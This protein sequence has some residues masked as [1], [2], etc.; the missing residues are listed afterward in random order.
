MPAALQTR[1]ERNHGGVGGLEP[2]M[3]AKSVLQTPDHQYAA[4]Q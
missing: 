3:H 1:V 4:D 2:E